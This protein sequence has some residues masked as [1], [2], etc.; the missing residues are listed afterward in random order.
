MDSIQKLAEKYP[1]FGVVHDHRASPRADV[2]LI[3]PISY[4]HTRVLPA[5]ASLLKKNRIITASDDTA[6]LTAYK[7]LRTQVLQRMRANG[8]STLAVTSPGAGEGKTLTSINLAISLAKEVNHTVL[9]VDLD[10][11][12]P[13]VARYFGCEPSYGLRDYL[14]DNIPLKDILFNPGIERLAV[15]PGSKPLLDSSE[16]LSTPKMVRL[17]QE[18]KGRYAG[19]IVIY[20]MPPILLADDVIAFSPNVDAVLL[21]V[22]EGKTHK[23]D[24]KKAMDLLQVVNV[25]GTVLNQTQDAV[26][27]YY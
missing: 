14:T 12:R 22:Q 16:L 25:V 19:R 18:M 9:L 7:M 10:L 1:G 4:T 3:E 26:P 21:V 23:N 13:S 17:A 2:P 24:L 20:D 8:W 5:P 27:G 15:L 11:R 6:A